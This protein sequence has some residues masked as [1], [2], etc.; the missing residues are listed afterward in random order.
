MFPL[1]RPHY[2]FA[3]VLWA[4]SLAFAASNKS[5]PLPGESDTGPLQ[6]TAVTF[7]L[8]NDGES[9]KIVVSSNTRL[10]RFDMIDEG[11]SVIFDPKT[12]DYLGLEHR[13]YTYWQFSWPKVRDAVASTKRYQARITELGIDNLNADA[14][15]S[16]TNAAPNAAPADTSDGSGYVWHQTTDKKQIAGVDCLRWE[17][18][19]VSGENVQVWCSTVPLP[20]VQDAMEHLASINDPMALVPVRDVI[21]TLVLTIYKSIS[22]GGVTPVLMTW[23][24]QR[25]QNHF[26]WL[27]TETREVKPTF[28][29]IPKLYVKTTLITMD[30]LMD[31]KDQKK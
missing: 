31:Q 4:S 11:Y 12:E 17:G 5:D 1:V 21:P 29:T 30:G 18:D 25:D 15:S 19:T 3:A 20:K 24:S 8:R 7:Q 10:F 2:L 22:R 13:N 27:K 16:S 6:V 28:F 23:G 26:G 9:R 14:P